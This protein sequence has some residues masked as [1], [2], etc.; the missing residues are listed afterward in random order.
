V[1]HRV[2]WQ[3][4]AL[5]VFVT[6]SGWATGFYLIIPLTEVNMMHFSEQFD[7]FGRTWFSLDYAEQA[8]F[9]SCIILAFGAL[10]GIIGGLIIG[11]G[12]QSVIRQIAGVHRHVATWAKA[13]VIG[14]LVGWGVGVFASGPLVYM[15]DH[16]GVNSAYYALFSDFSK[17]RGY[18]WYL[19]CVHLTIA[20]I[21]GALVGVAVGVSQ[22]IV[23]RHLGS[24]SQWWIPFSV[25]AWTLGGAVF[26]LTYMSLGGPVDHYGPDLWSS[27]EAYEMA[28]GNA[29]IWAWILG[30]IVV[31]AI[32]GICLQV[33][34][35]QSG[36]RD[37]APNHQ[38]LTV[39]K[40]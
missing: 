28:R 7:Y 10:S 27:F 20:A 16:P 29:L 26:A 32:T 37:A 6:M 12:Q 34:L 8:W 19:P 9:S 2:S 21:L 24:R 18:Y 38:A 35:S 36:N 30:G 3:L 40:L 31:G 4:F 25:A 5:W 14:M 11:L 1:K 22:W 17:A 13:T 15:L 33:V 39:E 23:I